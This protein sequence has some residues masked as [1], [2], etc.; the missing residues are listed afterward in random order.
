MDR[1]SGF[2]PEGWGFESLAMRQTTLNTRIHSMEGKTKAI[3]AHLTLIGWI[4]ALVVNNDEKDDLASFYIRQN[5][6]LMLLSLVLA[7][8]PILNFIAWILPLVLWVMSLIGAIQGEKKITPLIG[9]YFQDW[10][11]S[12]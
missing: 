6:G 4:I 7:I 3:V 1:A 10:F 8:I 9:T 2:E 11:K 5:L 12:L